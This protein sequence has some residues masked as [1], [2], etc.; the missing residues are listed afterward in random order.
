MNGEMPENITRYYTFGFAHAH[1]VNGFTYDKDVVVEIT[2]PD[3]RAV[4]LRAF[5]REWA[6]EYCEVP[7]LKW[8]PRGVKVLVA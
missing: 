2:A 1:A 6:F 8:F 4:M 5:G 3:P 7:D